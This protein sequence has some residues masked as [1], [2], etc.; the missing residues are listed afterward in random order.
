MEHGARQAPDRHDPGGDRNAAALW[1]T[2]TNE[3]RNA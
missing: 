2:P 1:S 3:V